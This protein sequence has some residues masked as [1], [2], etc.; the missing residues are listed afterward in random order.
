MSYPESI[1]AHSDYVYP[2]VINWRDV[3]NDLRDAGYSGYRIAAL[4]GKEWSTVQGWNE[5][6]EPRH[7]SGVAL[8][9]LHTRYCGAQATQKR[10]SE[11]KVTL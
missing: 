7:S 6:K 11:A 2:A 10:Q 1:I 4:L 9:T 3:L 8:L 5:G